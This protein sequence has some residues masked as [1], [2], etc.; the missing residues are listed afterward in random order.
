MR[1][2]AL[3]RASGVP[4]PTIKFYLR[5][6]LLP[7]GHRTSPNQSQYD[8]HHVRRL[9]LIR[10]LTEL[11]G[12]SLN[13][14]GELLR[15]AE[16]GGPGPE[17]LFALLS[18]TVTARVSERPA[19]G[20]EPRFTLVDAVM[21]ERGWRLTD[22]DEHRLA[23]ATLLGM[24][25]ELDLHHTSATMRAYAAAAT[26]TADSR[27]DERDHGPDPERAVLA[28]V[29]DDALFTALRRMAQVSAALPGDGTTGADPDAA[30]TLPAPRTHRHDHDPAAGRTR[31]SGR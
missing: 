17:E 16:D 6:G 3:S 30:A 19:A 18:R 12:Y 10:S 23:A 21:R 28:A 5:E 8:E 31:V 13:T 15:L 1:M 2:A 25:H 22:N 26:L 20:V 4:V 7:P 11:G 24:M 27:A 14:V 9:A 29:L